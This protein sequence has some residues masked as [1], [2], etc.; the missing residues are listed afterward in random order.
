MKKLA[1]IGGGA[2]GL[3]AAVAAASELRRLGLCVRPSTQG[4]AASPGADGVE[5]VV[6]EADDR[7]GR[8]ILATGNGRCNFSIA[9][10]DAA[11]YRNAPFV[12]RS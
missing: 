5:V 12:G 8:S 4:G 9:R 7:V 1:I 3:A 10:V 6:H 2:A 11:V